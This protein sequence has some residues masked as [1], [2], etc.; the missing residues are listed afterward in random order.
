MALAFDFGAQAQRRQSGNAQNR[1]NQRAVFVAEPKHFV[2]ERA[3][4]TRTE[5]ARYETL[6]GQFSI[7]RSLAIVAAAREKYGTTMIVLR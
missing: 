6:P 5:S 1:I 3:G 7:S 4:V 2:F